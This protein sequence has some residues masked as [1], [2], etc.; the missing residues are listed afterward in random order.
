M[1]HRI[2]GQDIMRPIFKRN[3]TYYDPRG[4]FDGSFS[5]NIILGI[6]F[7]TLFLS[8][9]LQGFWR[10]GGGFRTD[11]HNTGHAWTGALW[12]DD[13]MEYHEQWVHDTKV[14]FLL[15]FGMD[16]ILSAFPEFATQASYIVK[17]TLNPIIPNII[18]C[19]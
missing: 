18:V 1:A 12:V 17:D 3:M 5:A 6:S 8:A 9:L 13:L 15:L 2:I 14:W 11:S 4:T 16:G 10:T 7:W 19:M